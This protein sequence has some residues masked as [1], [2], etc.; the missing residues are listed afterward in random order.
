MAMSSRSVYRLLPGSIGVHLSA[1]TK[2]AKFFLRNIKI[3]SF[4][5]A[6]ALIKVDIE[7]GIEISPGLQQR[8]RHELA[9]VASRHVLS[10]LN[11]PRVGSSRNSLRILK[12]NDVRR[13]DLPK[14]LARSQASYPKFPIAS[15]YIAYQKDQFHHAGSSAT[16]AHYAVSKDKQIGGRDNRKLALEPIGRSLI[17]AQVP[18][19]AV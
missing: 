5:C 8:A 12:V 6:L 2:P 15:I 13:V 9:P 3:G 1:R 17:K 14:C 4:T 10:F 11:A 19:E 18:V 7:A 16:L